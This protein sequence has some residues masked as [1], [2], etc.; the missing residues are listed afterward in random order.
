MFPYHR[1]FTFGFLGFLLF[2]SVRTSAQSREHLEK[3]NMV[4]P[5]A[6]LLKSEFIFTDAPFLQ[7][8]ASTIVALDN[9]ELMAS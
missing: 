2:A 3:E 8:H 6:L 5:E 7:C 9:G 4:M 1:V